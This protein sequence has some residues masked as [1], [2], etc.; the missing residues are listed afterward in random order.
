MMKKTTQERFYKILDR[1]ERFQERI[2]D[3]SNNHI[4]ET[5]GITFTPLITNL[6]K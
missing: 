1:P 6:N 5:S 2:R 3:K 4:N